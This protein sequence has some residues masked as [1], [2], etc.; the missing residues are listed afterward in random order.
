MWGFLSIVF[1]A[2]LKLPGVVMMKQCVLEA[3]AA[4]GECA[5]VLRTLFWKIIN[6]VGITASARIHS[7][8]PGDGGGAARH[9]LSGTEEPIGD[10]TSAS[11]SLSPGA[12]DGSNCI[13]YS[14]M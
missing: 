3:S 5:P 1:T 13:A 8:A 4:S 10:L 9:V 7:A 11:W 2:M 6:L 14:F 12:A